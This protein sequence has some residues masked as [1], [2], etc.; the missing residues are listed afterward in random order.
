MPDSNATPTPTVA[1]ETS[2]VRLG[3]LREDQLQAA[4][5][6][7]EQHG[8][9]LVQAIFQRGDI[10]TDRLQALAFDH[11]LRLV[12]SASDAQETTSSDES[13][14]PQGSDADDTAELPVYPGRLTKED[15]LSQYLVAHQLLTEGQ[16][17][18][19]QHYMKD[20]NTGLRQAI[21]EIG[22][23]SRERLEDLAREQLE[24]L[25]QQPITN[26]GGTI[27]L[28]E[29]PSSI[30]PNHEQRERDI[31]LE[32]NQISKSATFSDLFQEMV[33]RAFDTRTTDIHIDPQSEF[34]RV[35]FR[36]DGYLHDVLRL[37]RESGHALTSRIKVAGNLNIV[38]RRLPQDGQ[39]QVRH[40]DEDRTL[41]LASL[42]T[43]YGEKV[44]LRINET[45][46]VSRD[47]ARLGLTEA[48]Q[49]QLDALVSK[50]YGAVLVAGPVGSGKT[51][52]LYSC[53]SKV[54]VP[55]RNL[56][57]IED[58]IE[59]RLP[60]SNQVQIDPRAGLT[61]GS[62]LRAILR[63]DPNVLMIGE[64]RDDETA[65]IGI[66]AALTGVLVFST[67]HAGDAAS[68]VSALYNFGIPGY[69]LASG[70]IGVVSQRLVR[71]IC[72]Y[73]SVTQPLSETD[74]QGL[75]TLGLQS[76]D[77][78][79]SEITLYRGRGCEACFET[80]Y[81]GRVGIFEIFEITDT[82]RELVLAQT[83]KDVLRQVAIDEGMIPLRRVALDRVLDGSTTLDEIFRAIN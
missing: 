81:L 20:H 82:I 60:G 38:E 52:T 49:L 1:P 45:L 41:R 74:I 7:S 79:L 3:L 66:R 53:L 65:Q 23:I 4:L 8:C 78:S 56:M 44:V 80:G 48:Q 5:A 39:I 50:P 64:I 63:Q 6:H 13:E 32:L 83:T 11:L 36:I 59:Y 40:A 68:T 71:R 21:L 54:N 27:P 34:Y 57:T 73:C 15:R 26:G 61:F 33:E 24:W 22:I 2:L 16:L 17:S 72:P 19:V 76:L 30:L 18:S 28:V 25:I 55:G 51:T 9:P 69:T 14:P 42:P 77:S 75:K 58:P 37:E 70:L 12:E 47:F 67:I 10:A 46:S 62:G 31:R 35:R 43:V 29:P